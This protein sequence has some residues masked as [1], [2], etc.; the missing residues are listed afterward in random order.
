MYYYADVKMKQKVPSTM[1][2]KK[3]NKS[4][5]RF[6]FFEVHFFKTAVTY[7]Y[8]EYSCLKMFHVSSQLYNFF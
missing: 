1:Q 2:N 4:V 7:E 5:G 8:K 3:Y 6:F